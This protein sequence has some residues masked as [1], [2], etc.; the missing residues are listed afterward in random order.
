MTP[1]ARWARRP[2]IVGTCRAGSSCKN[3]GR[4]TWLRVLIKCVS[5]GWGFAVT[6]GLD[7]SSHQPRL[8]GWSLDSGQG[9]RVWGRPPGAYQLTSLVAD[10]G[11]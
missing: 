8:A 11:P 7:W 6:D 9:R 4:G 1:L 10:S 3:G 5:P 2:G